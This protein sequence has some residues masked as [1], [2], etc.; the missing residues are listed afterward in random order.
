MKS[1]TGFKVAEPRSRQLLLSS[2]ELRLKSPRF[3]SDQRSSRHWYVLQALGGP[4]LN[5]ETALL[6]GIRIRVNKYVAWTA[7]EW[8]SREPAEAYK[9]ALVHGHQSPIL[10]IILWT[11]NAQ[12]ASLGY[13]GLCLGAQV[14]PLSTH[15]HQNPKSTLL[16]SM[17]CAKF[18]QV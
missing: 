9:V 13:C 5:I 6:F 17:F 11:S 7:F 3:F 15:A 2:L 8:C 16:K 1:M 18:S 12:I 4:V 10:A 14:F